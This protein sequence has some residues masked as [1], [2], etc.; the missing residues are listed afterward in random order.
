MPLK[1]RSTVIAA[2]IESVY[3][4]DSVPTG[5]ANAMLVSNVELSPLNG[6]TVKRE[7]MRGGLGAYQDIHVGVHVMLSFDVEIAGAGAAALAAGTPPAYG[8]LNRACGW[9]ENSVAATST[10]YLPVSQNEESVTVYPWIDGQLHKMLGVRGS[11]DIKINSKGIAYYRYNLTGLWADPASVA[12]P[13]VDFSAFQDPLPVSNTNTPTFTLH[14]FS[15]VLYSLEVQQGNTVVHRDLVGVEDVQITTREMV[16]KAVIEAPALSTKN[17]FT[18]AKAN[19]LAAM[20]LVH[21]TV[22][23]GIVQFDAPQAQ[24]KAPKYGQQD[25]NVTIEMDLLFVPTD[26]EDDEWQD[27]VK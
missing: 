2:K 17:F 15:A 26:A 10:T 7:N 27:T 11:R 4:T 19:T 8:V 20:Q 16:G 6:D 21:G 13:T 18:I 3:G 22:A 12:N 24:I 1:I 25:G 9:A 5:A 14:G 23:G